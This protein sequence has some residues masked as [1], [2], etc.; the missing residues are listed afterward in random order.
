MLRLQIMRDMSQYGRLFI[1]VTPEVY[2]EE[3]Y[4]EDKTAGETFLNTKEDEGFSFVEIE[5]K[6]RLFS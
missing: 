1:R 4:K 2:T 6:I 5:F 3:S